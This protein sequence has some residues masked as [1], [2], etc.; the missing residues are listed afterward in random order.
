INVPA[1]E[2]HE[3]TIADHASV[4]GDLIYINPWLGFNM[5]DNPFKIDTRQ[6]PV[7]FGSPFEK[8]ILTKITIPEGY[9]VEEVPAN[10][11]FALPGGMGK[12]ICS[13]NV[14]GNTI[15]CTSMLVVNKALFVQ[16]EYPILREFYTQFIAKQGEQI[17]LKKK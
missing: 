6:Y 4:A 13:I 16:A 8:S 5:T 1:K 15:S 14:L 7:D 2:I 9:A 11:I 12:Y 17:V 10:K 3:V